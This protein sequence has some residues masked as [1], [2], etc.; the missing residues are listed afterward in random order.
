M[1]AK[2]KKGAAKKPHVKARDLQ[3]KKEPRGGRKAGKDQQE[4]LVIKMS[5]AY[6][7]Q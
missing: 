3:A 1:A 5:E 6:V 2:H 4:Y 7:T